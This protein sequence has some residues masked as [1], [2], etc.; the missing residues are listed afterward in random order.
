MLM[1]VVNSDICAAG[2]DGCN[3]DDDDVNC[4]AHWVLMVVVMMTMVIMQ[5]D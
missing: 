2:V 5:D 4:D 1:V 3:D